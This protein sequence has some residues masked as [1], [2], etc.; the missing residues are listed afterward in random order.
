MFL[1]L[2]E[3]LHFPLKAFNSAALP[4]RLWYPRDVCV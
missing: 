4:H 3:I 2:S 1:H